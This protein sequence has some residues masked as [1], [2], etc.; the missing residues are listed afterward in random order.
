[1][2]GSWHCFSCCHNF[3]CTGTLSKITTV[4]VFTLLG[5]HAVVALRCCKSS[6]A[7]K[8]VMEDLTKTYKPR[9]LSCKFTPDGFLSPLTVS[10]DVN[11]CDAWC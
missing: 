9:I 6:A 7:C 8:N 11:F 4:T 2:T 3:K 1:M 10:G 5:L